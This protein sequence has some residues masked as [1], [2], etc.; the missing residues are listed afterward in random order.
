MNKFFLLFLIISGLTLGSCTPETIEYRKRK[1]SMAATEKPTCLLVRLSKNEKAV[2][3][4]R[5]NNKDALADAVIGRQNSTNL[6]IIRAFKK[7][8]DF[9]PVLFFYSK[10]TQ[11]I[12]D[13]NFE[14][15]EFLDD[16]LA[17]DESVNFDGGNFLTA[18]FGFTS[19]DTATYFDY[20]T[21]DSQDQNNGTTSRY[22]GS[23]DLRLSALV[24]MSDQFVQMRQ[25][26]P[27]YIR[28]TNLIG[29]RKNK[30]VVRSMNKKF[31][32]FFDQ[33]K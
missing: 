11:N 33:K 20:E 10:H 25:P 30:F 7:E 17:V 26:F 15:V 5:D 31:H 6:E 4:F 22:H 12:M 13:K 1:L 27:Y 28:T 9:C 18:E 16:K 23:P 14:S 2:K 8:F 32:Y 19:Q 29:H 21:Y 24:I 3:A